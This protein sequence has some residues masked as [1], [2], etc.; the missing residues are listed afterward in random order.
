MVGTTGYH[1]PAIGVKGEHGHVALMPQRLAQR[2]AS[3]EVPKLG[4]VFV[5][6]RDYRTVRAERH[7]A[8][9]T[10]MRQRLPS[11]L[12]RVD[13]PELG[14]VLASGHY[15]LAIGTEGDSHDLL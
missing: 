10:L 11:P 1:G 2:F 13:P 15:V 4:Q 12:P 14:L 3:G 6:G 8:N 7:G 9:R 5:G